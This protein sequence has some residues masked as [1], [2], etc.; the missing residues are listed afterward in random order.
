MLCSKCNKEF[1]VA[2]NFC[3]VC[4]SKLVK[5]PKDSIDKQE[6][7]N[8]EIVTHHVIDGITYRIRAR[9]SEN[10]TESLEEMLN[11]I[12]SRDIE[13]SINNLSHISPSE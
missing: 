9:S 10:A 1:P 4:G 2:D 6:V 8:F 12:I 3:S 13:K 7:E 5:P 11:G